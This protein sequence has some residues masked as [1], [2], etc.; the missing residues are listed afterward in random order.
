MAKLPE[1][2]RARLTGP[3]G[4]PDPARM[5]ELKDRVCN[6]TGG[7]A[8]NPQAFAQ[9]RQTLCPA[10]KA[11]DPAGLPQQVADRFKGADGQIDQARLTQFRTRVCS[12]DPS[13]L[14]AQRGQA[15]QGG[16][17]PAANGGQ[18]GQQQAQG[19]GNRGRG[20]FGGFGGRGRN[21]GRWNLSLSHTIELGNTVL[22][23]PVGPTLDLLHGDAL[24]GG[25]VAR[26]TLSLEGGVFYNGFGTRLSGSY[27]SGTRVEGSGVPGSSDLRFGDLFTLDLRMFADLG[28]QEKLVKAAPFFK[29]ARLSFSVN[30]V[31]NAHQRVTDQNGVVPLRY[32]PDLIDPTGRS[33]EIEFRKLF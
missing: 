33:F 28:R 3:D 8:F 23:S 32:Q 13:Q 25:G 24:S 21:G 20:G 12:V 16:A 10:D 29:N 11:I 9:L 5:K 2:M 18:Q 31:F 1:P 26:H 17:A 30:N 19:G 14:A 4:K 22:V 15:A 7:P 6:G 27:K